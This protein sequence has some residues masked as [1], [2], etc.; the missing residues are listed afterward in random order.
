M[1]ESIH[2]ITKAYSRLLT[3]YAT[4][5]YD[6]SKHSLSCGDFWLHGAYEN[7]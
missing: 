1:H 4:P 5:V 3:S 7:Q 6:F 2:L